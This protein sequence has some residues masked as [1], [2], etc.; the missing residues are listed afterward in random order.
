MQGFK[1]VL[2]KVISC[3]NIVNALPEKVRK[4]SVF[5]AGKN[6]LKERYNRI[7]KGEAK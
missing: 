4:N 5:G 3:G 6:I 1:K 7:L 2:T